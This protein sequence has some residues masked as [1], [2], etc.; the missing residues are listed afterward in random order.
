MRNREE[1]LRGIALGDES[2]PG[3]EDAA[4]AAGRVGVEATEDDR[5]S[6]SFVS[7]EWAVEAADVSLGE[8]GEMM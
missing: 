6:T 5:P 1:E 8:D 2:T 4:A 3:E 7:G